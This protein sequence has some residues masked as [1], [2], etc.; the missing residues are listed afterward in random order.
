V[1]AEEADAM[2]S[3]IARYHDALVRPSAGGAVM[4]SDLAHQL[5]LDFARRYH[6]TQIAAPVA[7]TKGSK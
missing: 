5:T 4:G 7:T 6:E 3:V 2:A 1:K